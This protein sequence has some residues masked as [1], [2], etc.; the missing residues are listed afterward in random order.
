MPKRRSTIHSLIQGGFLTLALSKDEIGLFIPQEESRIDTLDLFQFVANNEIMLNGTRRIRMRDAKD[1]NTLSVS[2]I[3]TLVKSTAIMFFLLKNPVYSC[4]IPEPKITET[5][6]LEDI[7]VR[8][9]VEIEIEIVP[10]ETA[11]DGPGIL[12]YRNP[13]CAFEI[14]RRHK[15]NC[16]TIAARGKLI[17]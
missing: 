8:E 10:L 13:E 6:T 1:G 17:L 3:E 14:K 11:G 9:T 16:S 5:E 4:A 12:K 7:H 15:K 2:D